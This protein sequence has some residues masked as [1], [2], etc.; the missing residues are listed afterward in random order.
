MKGKH[1]HYSNEY[2]KNEKKIYH[3]R[4]G[5]TKMYGICPSGRITMCN[6]NAILL[7]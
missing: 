4:Q 2:W 1:Y 6:I 7:N 5:L 3:Q